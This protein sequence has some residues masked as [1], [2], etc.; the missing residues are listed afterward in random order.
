V[1]LSLSFSKFNACWNQ[2]LL[3]MGVSFAD[4]VIRTTGEEAKRQAR[5]F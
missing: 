5:R 2:Q 4:V 1:H 3:L